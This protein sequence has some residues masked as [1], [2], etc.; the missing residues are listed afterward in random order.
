MAERSGASAEIGDAL[1]C[2]GYRLF[3]WWHKVR[4]GA[5]SQEQFQAAVA[6]LRIAFVAEL[7]SA[8]NL[9]IGPKEKSPL[10]KTVCTCA[11]ILELE[12][13][14][15]TFATVAGVEP[16]NNPS[17]QALRPAVIWQY[18]SFGSQS[19]AGAEFVERLLTVNAILKAQN[20]SVLEFSTQSCQATRLGI[21]GPSLLP[22]SQTM[23]APQ[24]LILL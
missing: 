13:A 11:K 14:L 12:V 18:T 2:R 23:M 5:L 15:W 24:T 4:D 22:L 20:R 10:A 17:E 9:E 21:D 16:A 1:L 3:H 6:R 19:K 8:A 7:E